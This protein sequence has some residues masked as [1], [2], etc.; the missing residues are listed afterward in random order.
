[1]TDEQLVRTLKIAAE[2]QENIA[3]QMLLLISAERIENSLDFQKK[4]E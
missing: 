1:M 2:T 4:E 3:L